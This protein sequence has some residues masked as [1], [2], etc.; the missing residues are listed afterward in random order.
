METT[1]RQWFEANGDHVFA[2]DGDGRPA[3]YVVESDGVI[4]LCDANTSELFADDAP[5]STLTGMA[6]E[7]MA[8]WAREE[9][10]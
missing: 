4:C 9:A 3:L 8:E 10:R 2:E 1:V 5:A 6:E 7:L